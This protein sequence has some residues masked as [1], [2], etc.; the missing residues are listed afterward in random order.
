MER[1]NACFAELDDPRKANARP[2]LNEILIIGLCAMPCGGEDCSDMAVFGRA[3]EALLRQFLRLLHGIPSHDTFSRVFRLLD[4]AQFQAGFLR[5][6]D[7]F[8]EAVRGVIAIDG[9]TLR[10]SFD[11]AS[12]KSPL[13]LVSA[14]A[15]GGRLVPGQVATEE[16]SNEIIAVPKLLA[17]LSLNGQIVT[18]DAMSCQRAIAAQ[19]I[20]QGG[21]S[22]L[23]LKGN[24][25]TLRDDVRLYLDDAAHAT[26]LTLAG[27]WTAI[28]AVSKRATPSCVPRSNGS[29]RINGQAW[30]RSAKSS[31]NGKSIA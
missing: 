24:Q 18:V 26:T 27:R 15:V 30:P 14:W 10:R 11:R 25:G 9:K 4:P 28:T 2:A 13:H 31:V 17:M 6:M 8:A 7:N 19:V 21:D 5:F 20:E 23:A 29:Q 12:G 16:K 3:K 22:V 1:F